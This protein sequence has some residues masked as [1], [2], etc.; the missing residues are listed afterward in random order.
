MKSASR[1]PYHAVIRPRSDEKNGNGAPPS[2]AERVPDATDRVDELVISVDIDLVAQVADI[3]VDEVR[4]AEEIR[5]PDA[6]EDL[7]AR[8]DFVRIHEQELEQRELLRGEL[9]RLAGADDLVRV[10]VEDEIFRRQESRSRLV[11]SQLDADPREQLLDRERFRQV[12]VG[13]GIEAGDP[14]RHGVFRGEH[15]DRNG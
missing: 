5:A 15:D 14:I 8:M 9:D 10:S 2:D 3:D 7:V 11:A 1:P 12:V 4:F 13:A 6:V